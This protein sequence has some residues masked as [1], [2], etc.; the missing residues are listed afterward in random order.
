MSTPTKT[1]AIKVPFTAPIAVGKQRPT[2]KRNLAFILSV[3]WLSLLLLA[4][5]LH[6]VPLTFGGSSL[7]GL[8]DPAEIDY[9]AIAAPPF[10][11]GYLLGGDEI[12]RDILSRVISGAGVSLV[13]GIGAVAL[14]VMLG[15]PLGII[16]GFFGGTTNRI[17]SVV[18][19]IFLAFPALILLISLS[20]FMGAS[21]ATIIVGIALVQTPA[22]ARVARASAVQFAGR[23]FVQAARSL[24]AREFRVLVREVVPN[25][26]VPVV[27]YAMVLLA[28]AI[29]AEASLSFLGLGVPPPTASWGG[30]MGTG[31]G[32]LASAPHIVLVPAAVMFFTLLSISFLAEHFTKRFDIKEAA[33]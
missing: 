21:M 19:D 9:A 28:V 17:I 16:A 6:A 32:E 7:L 31:R 2:T 12:G 5:L 20:V 23:D 1:A 25:V 13:A 30:M 29:V 14:A 26:V 15:G 10:S 4:V 8:P 3:T 22:V 33:L 18:L 11:P 24:G 27:A